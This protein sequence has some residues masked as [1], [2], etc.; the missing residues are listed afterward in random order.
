MIL[1][2][3]L[4]RSFVAVAQDGALIRAAQRVHRTQS[5]LSMQ[6]KR[7]E[8]LVGQTLLLRRGRGVV[9]TAAG[10]EF[11][12]HA[13]SVLQAHDVAVSALQ[14]DAPA[15]NLRLGC[16]DAY[17]QELV[18]SAVPRMAAHFPR[19]R[20]T[21]TCAP[22]S[23]LQRL[24]ETGRLDVAVL[25][26][27]TSA[28]GSWVDKPQATRSGRLEPLVWVSDVAQLALAT[29]PLALALS[30]ADAVDHWPV[31]D[32]LKQAGRKFRLAYASANLAGVSAVVKAGLAI[33]AVARLAVPPDL[34]VLDPSRAGL[35]RLPTVRVSVQ[36]SPVVK[37]GREVRD[38]AAHL[39]ATLQATA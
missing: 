8:T 30:H 31:R 26:S 15:L 24:L 37:A 22:T 10:S 18:P 33:A 12:L 38:L 34:L 5:A 4:L 14:S 2:I 32:A 16:P 1:E 36:V 13:R 11:L 6:M 20:V 19:A 21:L 17:V 25:A 29:D 23:T 9:L 7:L 3:P 28:R 27:A 39:V 35:P